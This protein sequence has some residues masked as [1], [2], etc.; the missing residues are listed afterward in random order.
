MRERFNPLTR[1]RSSLTRGHERAPRAAQ[2]GFQ[3]PHEDSFF[4]DDMDDSVYAYL[5]E[6]TFQSPHEDS[7]FSDRVYRP[8]EM[9]HY[10]IR[11][12][13]LTRIRSSLT[14][15]TTTA[16]ETADRF[17]FNPLTRIRSSLTVYEQAGDRQVLVGFNPLTRIRSS[18]TH[19][20]RCND[21]YRFRTFQSPH[22]DSFFS[23]GSILG[24]LPSIYP[25]ESFNPLTRIR[26]S[27]TEE[28]PSLEV[29]LDRVSIPSRG[30]VLL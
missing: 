7:F 20:E 2:A 25:T 30:F 15:A 16:Y 6:E 4:S 21:V 19:C 24:I 11:F 18:L 22:E 5:W 29:V 17:C 13:P 14:Y 8:H 27:L 28:T 1:I 26:S 10:S 23:D 3:S 12:N 9:R